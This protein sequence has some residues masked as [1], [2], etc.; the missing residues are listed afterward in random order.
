MK[1]PDLKDLTTGLSPNPGKPKLQQSGKV[2]AVRK[3]FSFSKSHLDHINAVAM[4]LTNER[5]KP[6]N[7]SEAL[8]VIID[9]HKA[10]L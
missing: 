8:R 10:D 4:N 1:K 6:V 2:D 3:T 5:G 7:A 9:Q